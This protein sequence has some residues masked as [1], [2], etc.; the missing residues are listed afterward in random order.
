MNCGPMSVDEGLVVTSSPRSPGGAT[1]PE[2]RRR[3]ASTTG[4]AKGSRHEIF[5]L[6]EEA[7]IKPA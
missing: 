4:Y 2:G 7:L 6:E 5:K 3:T 1:R